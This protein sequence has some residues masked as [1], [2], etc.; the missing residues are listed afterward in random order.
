LALVTVMTKIAKIMRRLT[1]EKQKHRGCDD[2]S[3]P[4]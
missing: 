4:Q 1:M 3:K 2:V